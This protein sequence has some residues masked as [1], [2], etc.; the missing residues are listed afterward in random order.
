MN[1]V[2]GAKAD[3]FPPQGENNDDNSSEEWSGKRERNRLAE[4][5]VELLTYLESTHSQS[6]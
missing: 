5:I 4:N 1:I 3:I 6:Y 2:F